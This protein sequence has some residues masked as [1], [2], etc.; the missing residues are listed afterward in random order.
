MVIKIFDFDKENKGIDR[1]EIWKRLGISE[2]DAVIAP[3]SAFIVPENTEVNAVAVVEN[4]QVRSQAEEEAA[5]LMQKLVDSH[6]RLEQYQADVE[7]AK[8]ITNV[9]WNRSQ[10]EEQRRINEQHIAEILREQNEL[11]KGGI[12]LTIR[13]IE[14]ASYL[15][16]ALAHM[17]DDGFRTR[18]GHFMRLT[19]QVR[20]LAKN[21]LLQIEGQKAQLEEEKKQELS[22]STP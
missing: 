5:A 4:R 11:I 7:K 10:I 17:I 16:E 13:T 12:T 19:G 21:L 15:G 20:T 9:F 1:S 18:D 8:N 3:P 22:V 2:D 14:F 6:N